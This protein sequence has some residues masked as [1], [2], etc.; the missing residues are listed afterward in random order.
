MEH[1]TLTKEMRKRGREDKRGKEGKKMNRGEKQSY[2][3][4]YSHFK[5][6]DP[7]FSPTGN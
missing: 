5:Q 7:P 6:E 2:P 4:G 1:V 3:L